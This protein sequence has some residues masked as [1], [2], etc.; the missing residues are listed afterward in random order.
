MLKLHAPPDM[1]VPIAPYAQ[2]IEATEVNRL[3][4]ISGTMGLEPDGQLAEGFEAQCD[5]VWKNIEA[6][7]KS[8]GMGFSHLAKLT[9]WLAR[10]E[11]WRLA[12]QIRQRYLGDHKVAMSVVE[13]GFVDPAW[14]IEVEA[15]AVS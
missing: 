5:R 10:R 1:F 9:V 15:I 2:A 4:F 6:T 13:V 12:A 3:L 7:L 11:D 14:L 8:A